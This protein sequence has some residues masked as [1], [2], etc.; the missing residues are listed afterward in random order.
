MWL[1]DFK[2]GH[3]CGL[4]SPRSGGCVEYECPPVKFCDLPLDS[5]AENLACDEALLDTAEAGFSG[6]LLRVWE[7]QSYFVVLGYANKAASEANLE[8]CRQN[9]IPVLRR[10]T[11][12]GAV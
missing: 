8:F 1:V 4:E 11:G 3:C 9:A 10:C 2:F 7:P 6:E 5:P 12:G